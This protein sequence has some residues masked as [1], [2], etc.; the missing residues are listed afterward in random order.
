MKTLLFLLLI[1]SS[2]FATTDELLLVIGNNVGL[3][4][5]IPL[6]YADSDARRMYET[7]LE[8]GSVD[9]DRG[10]LLLNKNKNTILYSFRDMA[11]RVKE[12][13]KQGSIV[14]ILIYYS[15]HGG[16]DAFHIQGEELPMDTVRN[17]F[18]TM[19]ADLKILIADACYSGALYTDK[20]GRVGNAHDIKWDNEL[21]V[22]GSVI[23]SSSSAGELS[24]ESQDLKGSLFTHYFISGLRGAADFDN[25]RKVSL[26]E[27]FTY[28]QRN[29]ARH[30][31]KSGNT[32]QTPGFDFNITG[33]EN[34][35]LTSLANGK[36][37]AEVTISAED[38]LITIA[39]PAGQYL[40]Q[41]AESRAIFLAQ[42]DLTWGGTK[43][44]NPAILKPYPIDILSGKGGAGLRYKP[45]SI[46]WSG[47][48][49]RD[50]L[51]HN[52]FFALNEVS[53][54]FEGFNLGGSLKA[55]YG[56]D[57]ISGTYMSVD[58]NFISVAGQMRYF[59]LRRSR[60]IW[61]HSAS[62]RVVVVRQEAKRPDET[63]IR[64]A[65]YPAIPV[66]WGQTMGLGVGTGVQFNLPW[67]LFFTSG[68]E[69]TLLV[70]RDTAGEFLYEGRL[71]L[72]LEFGLKF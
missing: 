61:F 9:K 30:S 38:T 51:L 53:C 43:E 10:Y 32:A 1:C 55:G 57:K 20:G 22:K 5:E 7:L 19:D 40:I 12:L 65:G 62:T 13:K 47:W 48:I 18:S 28:T 60:W 59:Q 50:F 3:S 45:F 71:P 33:T 64:T 11:G 34:I 67:S 68:I 15:G 41:H 2:L 17:F 36:A 37:F 72:Q 70:S 23:L 6:R 56:R 21:R 27:G 29:I 35:T 52:G 58:R 66:Q 31:L 24:K 39:L 49:I 42:A 26:W 4:D 16:N 54:S 44:I 8:L 25:D 14:E 63:A 46:A 69:P